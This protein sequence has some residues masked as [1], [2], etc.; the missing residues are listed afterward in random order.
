MRYGTGLYFLQASYPCG[1]RGKDEQE[2]A[3]LKVHIWTFV[4][5][6]LSIFSNGLHQPKCN[7]KNR[8]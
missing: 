6:F 7:L 5:A 8:N 3:V 1:I 2:K 4:T